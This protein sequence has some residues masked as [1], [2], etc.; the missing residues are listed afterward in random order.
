MIHAKIL[1]KL[2]AHLTIICDQNFDKCN[3]SNK[4][5]TGDEIIDK[6]NGPKMTSVLHQEKQN[7]HNF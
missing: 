6:I 1:R 2:R 7:D 5:I 4:I 3:N